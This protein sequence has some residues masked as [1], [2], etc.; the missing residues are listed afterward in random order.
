MFPPS[1]SLYQDYFTLISTAPGLNRAVPVTNGTGPL[2]DGQQHLGCGTGAFTGTPT[3]TGGIFGVNT[4]CAIALGANNTELN[5]EQLLAFVKR[6]FRPSA[7]RDREVRTR[8]A[9]EIARDG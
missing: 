7:R 8:G 1:Q 9:D 3:G 2:Q 6:D 4:P 5:T